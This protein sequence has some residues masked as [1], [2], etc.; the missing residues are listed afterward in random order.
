MIKLPYEIHCHLIEILASDPSPEAFSSLKAYGNTCSALVPPAQKHLFR[1][2]ALWRPLL[3]A[4]TR[5]ITQEIRR[6]YLLANI[7]AQSPVISNYISHLT[8]HFI[9]IKITD[10]SHGKECRQQLD[11]SYKSLLQLNRVTNLCIHGRGANWTSISLRHQ[12]IVAIQHLLLLRTIKAL[13]LCCIQKLPFSLFSLVAGVR[14]L[15]LDQVTYGHS[16]PLHSSLASIQTRPTIL[17]L[18]HDFFSGSDVKELCESRAIDLSSIKTLKLKG[19]N[20]VINVLKP[21]FVHGAHNINNILFL[22]TFIGR[23]GFADLL[24]AHPRVRLKHLV[25]RVVESTVHCGIEELFQELSALTHS[26]NNIERISLVVTFLSMSDG[27]AHRDVWA[28]LAK[29]IS[30]EIA[31]P[32]FQLF[33]IDLVIFQ[34]RRNV[35]VDWSTFP[36]THLA[37]LQTN[38]LQFRYQVTT[39]PDCLVDTSRVNVLM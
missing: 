10:I 39:D 4:E 15:T 25:S 19:G 18:Y 1:V 16:E 30:D 14:T 5:D 35:K 6:C 7:L 8:I 17:V 36:G 12:T 29:L 3:G 21:L 38:R 11:F 34:R 24:N 13:K 22:D 2:V 28:Q 23:Q 26:R 33:S 9:F 32:T 31:W 27:Y 37:A 20:V